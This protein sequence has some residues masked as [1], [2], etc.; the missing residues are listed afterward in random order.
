MKTITNE[1]MFTRCQSQLPFVQEIQGF[2]FYRQNEFV[3][4]SSLLSNAFPRFAKGV[5]FSVNDFCY[6]LEIIS[7]CENDC[8][9]KFP[10][11]FQHTVDKMLIAYIWI[12]FLDLSGETRT[13]TRREKYSIQKEKEKMLR[14]TPN[15]SLWASPLSHDA[16]FDERTLIHLVDFPPF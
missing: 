5:Q 6:A 13:K 2:S 14:Y 12:Y 9:C 16:A 15:P 10:N 1:A 11:F 8:Q 7:Q 3:N 4:P